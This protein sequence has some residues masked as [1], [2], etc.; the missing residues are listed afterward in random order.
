MAQQYAV[1]I[2]NV[3]MGVIASK[4]EIYALF[5]E[6][7]RSHN[8]RE[9][10]SFFE[11]DSRDQWHLHG[12][13]TARKNLLVTKFKKQYWHIYINALKTDDDI[14]NWHMYIIKDQDFQRSDRLKL[15]IEN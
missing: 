13:F 6:L 11:K 7:L 4:Q 10:E 3:Q 14:K 2:K 8:G 15:S 9:V 5:L 1:T 12:I